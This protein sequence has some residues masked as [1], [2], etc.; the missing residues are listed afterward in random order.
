MNEFAGDRTLVS[1]HAAFLF[2][3]TLFSSFLKPYATVRYRWFIEERL[4][5]ICNRP[6]FK[7]P[8]IVVRDTL[9]SRARDE[10]E[11]PWPHLLKISLR[12]YGSSLVFLCMTK[13]AND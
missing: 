2:D 1:S 12:W 7:V 6:S 3:K 4:L 10:T 5:K 13:G 11:M 8:Y 9:Y